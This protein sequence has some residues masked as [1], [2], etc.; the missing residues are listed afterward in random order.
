MVGASPILELLAA[1]GEPKDREYQNVC[2]RIKAQPSLISDLANDDQSVDLTFHLVHHEKRLVRLFCAL[3]SAKS[4]RS[5]PFPSQGIIAAIIILSKKFVPILQGINMFLCLELLLTTLLP[6]MND[7][8][9]NVRDMASLLVCHEN[10]VR[11]LVC[12]D[13][14]VEAIKAFV[15]SPD[16]ATRS[17]RIQEAWMKKLGGLITAC[18]TDH[19]LSAELRVWED[20][21]YAKG[22]LHQAEQH[23]A[24]NQQVANFAHMHELSPQDRHLLFSQHF[25]SQTVSLDMPASL[26]EVLGKLGIDTPTSLAQLR[27]VIE[28]VEGPKTLALLRTLVGSF[29]CVWCK[30]AL[31]Q[32]QDVPHDKN[33]AVESNITSTHEDFSP[34]VFGQRVGIW[35]VLLST[36]ALTTLQDRQRAKTAG[37]LEEKLTALAYGFGHK[38]VRLAGSEKIRS[39]LRVP[40]FRTKYGRGR[41]I[42]W[43][44]DLDE[45]RESRMS[46]QVIR[47]WAIVKGAKIDAI[48]EH[49]GKSIQSLYST[50]KVGRCCQKCR[51]DSGPTSPI[52][53]ENNNV[54]TGSIAQTQTS[55]DVR[56]M[57]PIL[58]DLVD[59]FYAF[60]QP[61]LRSQIVDLMAPELP[62]Q[63]STHEM[64]V[65]CYWKSSSLILGRSGTGKTTCL[66]FKLIGKHLASKLDPAQRPIRQILLTRSRDLA[67]KLR[68]YIRNSLRTLS[69]RSLED[70]GSSASIHEVRHLDLS[71][72]TVLS[73]DDDHYPLVCTFEDFL[74]LLENT[75]AIAD[76]QSSIARRA[77]GVVRGSTSVSSQSDQYD[78]RRCVDF[79]A[80]KEVYWPTFS[81]ETR[82]LPSSL[83]FAEIMGVIKGSVLSSDTLKPLTLKEYLEASSRI[84][85]LFTLE[86]ERTEVYRAFKEYERLKRYRS[87]HDYVDRV[88]DLLQAIR[89]NPVLRQMMG[90]SVEELYVDEI[91]DHRCVDIAL[92]LTL[93]K[94]ARGFHV[95]GDTAQ[96]ISQDATLRFADIKTLVYRR[97]E[98]CMHAKMFQLGVNYRS[99][100]GIV[101]LAAFVM[102]IL[103]KAFPDTVDKLTPEAGHFQG[104]LPVIFTGCGPEILSCDKTS[105]EDAASRSTSFG[106]DQVVLVRDD[107]AKSQLHSAVDNVGL[108]L[109]ILQSK[110]MEFSD[111]K[112][113]DFFSTCADPAGLRR[114]PALME[115]GVAAFDCEKHASMCTELKR[116]YVAITRAQ[117]RLFF[118]ESLDEKELSPI[119]RMLTTSGPEPIVK[120]VKR[121]DPAFGDYVE[122]LRTHKSSRPEDWIAKGW[123]MLARDGYD[124]ARFCFEEAHYQQGITIATARKKYARGRYLGANQDDAGAAAAYESAAAMY[125]EARMINDAVGI[126][127]AVG[128]YERAADLVL[129]ELC[130]YNEAA[131]LFV[132][133]ERFDRASACYHMD[134]QYENAADALLRG[135]AF[136]AYIDYMSENRGVLSEKVIRKQEGTYRILLRQRRISNDHQKKAISLLG[137]P[138]EREQLYRRY[139]MPDALDEL[140]LENKRFG[141]LFRHRLQHG[142]LDT[143]FQ[144]LLTKSSV[145][146]LTGIPDDQIWTLIDYT[147]AGRLTDQKRR[148]KTEVHKLLHDL[149]KVKNARCAKRVQQWKAALGCIAQVSTTPVAD[150]VSIG[151]TRLQ[152]IT[153][154]QVV[155]VY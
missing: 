74:R 141:D 24:R 25:G 52:I 144:L 12:N 54:N 64:E 31:Q 101:A 142:H 154:L 41:Y 117:S 53:F 86:V 129:E 112:L 33:L 48:L 11:Q 153:S 4:Q 85:P 28:D 103:W 61:V 108:T 8:P 77:S 69:A 149:Q 71:K 146:Q 105:S 20:L 14:G 83:V 151:D 138:D 55:L 21:K 50:E 95:A 139:E 136:D 5:G 58:L 109:T 75:A 94:D 115:G 2:L 29:P 40:T 131:V 63:L 96:A 79:T 114:L 72:A 113:V 126:F 137:S 46:K 42:L 82:R 68:T 92:F 89:T 145:D 10:I 43:Q 124:E 133:A 80:F 121:G 22:L 39:Q 6:C 65:I 37:S 148:Q 99:H 81:T 122:L 155:Q 87:E 30:L 44:I 15:H 106:A 125:L 134:K 35:D 78:I 32:G 7:S 93:M 107:E 49:V 152:L 16:P 57:D 119:L 73:L 76:G 51:L 127:R 91:Q 120:V 59:K 116:L 130:E 60:T 150:L 90:S 97:F 140:Y 98:T 36:S 62:Y 18:N 135:K 84:A 102:G 100:H 23:L 19:G 128:W 27:Q 34:D 70:S 147:L 45:D 111:V 88:T 67:D 118:I 38:S 104:P 56:S 143:A 66:M 1:E 17:V 110:G 26:C 123:A 13:S 9:T 132:N 47:V 3:F